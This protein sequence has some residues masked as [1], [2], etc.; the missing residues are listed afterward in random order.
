MPSIGIK[1]IMLKDMHIPG[2]ETRWY[3][4]GYPGGDARWNKRCPAVGWEGLSWKWHTPVG[5]DI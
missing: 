3:E 5:R 4:R 2:E 1:R